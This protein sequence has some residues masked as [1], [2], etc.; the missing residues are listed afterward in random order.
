MRE[1]IYPASS[2]PSV[3]LPPHYTNLCCEGEIKLRSSEPLAYRA[4]A[5]VHSKLSV[6]AGCS[7]AYPLCTC[8]PIR[9]GRG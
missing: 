9:T 7:L 4:Y 1:V 6:K 2:I 8:V 3:P 5:L